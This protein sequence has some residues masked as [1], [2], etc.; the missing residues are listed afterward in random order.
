[1][2]FPAVPAPVPAPAAAQF[3]PARPVGSIEQW[4]SNLLT[5]DKGIL[6]ED[7][8]LQVGMQSRYTRAA[9]QIVLFLGNKHA[10]QPLSDVSLVPT[11]VPASLYVGVSPSPSQL[12]PKQQVQVA[13]NTAAQQ[14]FQGVPSLVLSYTL[15]GM[16]VRQELRLPVAVHKFIAPE[17]TIAK[18][19]FF[20]EWRVNSHAP[21]KAQEM[22]ERATPLTSPTIVA[23]MRAANLGVEHGYLDPSPYNEAGAGNFV[24]GQPG[25]EQ[26]VR[27]M[28]RI[29]GNPQ[30]M[31]Q[32]RV[33]ASSPSPQVAEAVKD[34]L[35]SQMRTAAM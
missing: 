22:L 24:Y 7:Q 9:G 2:A 5:K 34:L 29:E 33:T 28:V 26:S 1:M 14:P 10:E 3:A 11:N 35:V 15:G 8:Y 19:T 23:I 17:P 21:N 25:M 4:F 30:N 32:F 13:V 12:A 16:P 27:V 18:E 20:A 31:S 6:Y